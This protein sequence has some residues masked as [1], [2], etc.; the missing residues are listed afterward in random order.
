MPRIW[1]RSS[2]QKL[3]SFTMSTIITTTMTMTIIMITMS[4]I[5]TMTRTITTNT[6]MIMITT[7][8][9]TIIMI[10][11]TIITIIMRM[12]S[13]R[14]GDLRRRRHIPGRSWSIF[15]RNLRMRRDM[16]PFSAQKVWFRLETARG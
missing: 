6:I 16:A 2:W 8:T 4:T 5:M 3:R 14:A 11:T 12:I 1:K 13:L 9:M 10:T 15:W 7:M